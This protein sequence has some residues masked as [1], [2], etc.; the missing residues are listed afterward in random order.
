MASDIAYI[1]L[2]NIRIVYADDC[3]VIRT[4]EPHNVITMSYED[5]EELAYM[6]RQTNFGK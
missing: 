2:T 1:E 5:F 3:V 6:I 4:I